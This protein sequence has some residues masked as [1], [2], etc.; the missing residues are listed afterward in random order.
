MYKILIL[1]ILFSF[2]LTAL[3]EDM[4]KVL[5]NMKWKGFKANMR[6]DLKR[7]GKE[8]IIK[9]M[10]I[11]ALAEKEGQKI[12]AVFT[13]PS[14]MKGMAFLA[15]CDK[16]AKDKRYIYLRALRRVKKVPANGENFMLRDFLSLY[17]LKPRTELWNYKRLKEDEEEIVLEAKAKN[18]EII[19][20]TGYSKMKLYIDKKDYHIKKTLFYSVGGK[21]IRI[22]KVIST[23]KIKGNIFVEK[24]ETDDLQEGVKAEITL[25]DIKVEKPSKKFF[26]VRYLKTL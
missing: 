12:L 22:Q 15:Y 17:L 3:Q 1:G 23:K 26:T 25:S 16:K 24:M 11:K 5:G 10:K 9:K 14:N 19:N 2:S 4:L 8:S 7:E 18:E 21:L 13:F 6:L 20:L